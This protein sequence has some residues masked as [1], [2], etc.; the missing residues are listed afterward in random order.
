MYINDRYSKIYHNYFVLE[1][2]NVNKTTE[3]LSLEDLDEQLHFKIKNRTKHEAC[4]EMYKSTMERGR[5]KI[6][7]TLIIHT[8]LVTPSSLSSVRWERFVARLLQVVIVNRQREK[9]AEKKFFGR[10]DVVRFAFCA[11]FEF[12]FLQLPA[13]LVGLRTKSTELLRFRY[14]EY[15]IRRRRK[16]ITTVAKRTHLR[17]TIGFKL[18]WGF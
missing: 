13:A 9:W 1:K 17:R 14:F 11:N 5:K 2:Y 7:S 16:T 12:S 10:Y 4:R 15:V 8:S 6:W 3:P 18:D